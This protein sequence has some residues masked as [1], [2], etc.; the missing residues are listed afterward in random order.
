MP[1]RYNGAQQHYPVLALCLPL[2]ESL[3]FLSQSTKENQVIQ[4]REA[5]IDVEVSNLRSLIDELK[6]LRSQWPMILKESKLVANSLNI[7]AEFPKKRKSRKDVE[8]GGDEADKI[9]SREARA[10]KRDVFHT[11]VDSVISGLTTRFDAANHIY[12]MFSFLWE[13]LILSEEEILQRSSTIGSFTIAGDRYKF[14]MR[15]PFDRLRSLQN[16][17]DPQRS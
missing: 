5:T 1:G 7:L 2:V 14:D 6:E 16:S 12:H 10:F 9:E 3:W 8:E 17:S 11:I 15:F 13:Y 4:A